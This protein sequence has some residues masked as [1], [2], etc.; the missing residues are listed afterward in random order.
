[1]M[2]NIPGPCWL[3]AS[4][5]PS[6]C[7]APKY[8]ALPRL[9]CPHRVVPP[10]LNTSVYYEW[11]HT[12]KSAYPQTIVSTAL[13][14]F[15]SIHFSRLLLQFSFNL[16]V[17]QRGGYPAALAIPSTVGMVTYPGPCVYLKERHEASFLSSQIL[18]QNYA[19]GHSPRQCCEDCHKS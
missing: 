8:K 11:E 16:P 18:L 12:G 9:I 14:F 10:H 4:N 2:F 1:M 17:L 6:Q 5:I 13:C 7:K 19:V 15:G 3:N